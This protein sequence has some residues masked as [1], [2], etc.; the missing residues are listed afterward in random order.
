MNINTSIENSHYKVLIVEDS[1]TQAM[2][3]QYTLESAGFIVTHSE[4]GANALEILPAL[5]P[6]LMISDV[7]M[8]GMD[9]Y[10]LCREVRNIPEMNYMPIILLTSLSDPDYVIHGLECGANG[11]GLAVMMK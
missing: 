5:K 4:N 1:I 9:G 8:P 7:V 11:W 6:H 10:G 3:L 2:R